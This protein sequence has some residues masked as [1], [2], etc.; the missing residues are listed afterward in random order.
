MRSSFILW[1]Q[2]C[3]GN[4][5]VQNSSIHL[6]FPPA[7][8]HNSCDREALLLQRGCSRC[9][10]FPVGGCSVCAEVQSGTWLSPLQLS[11]WY[12]SPGIQSTRGV[13]LAQPPQSPKQQGNWRKE[14]VSWSMALCSRLKAKSCA[15]ASIWFLG[16][17]MT[18]CSNG[19][20][21]VIMVF[22]PPGAVF[23]RTVHLMWVLHC[24]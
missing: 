10:L 9:W 11:G 6:V 8:P 15:C 23:W 4:M 14:A 7:H 22:W 18:Y 2:L 5:A 3:S 16:I 12:L 24:L 21:F 19:F 20:A 13:A 1:A 17:Q